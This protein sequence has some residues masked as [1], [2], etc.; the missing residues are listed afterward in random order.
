MLSSLPARGTGEKAEPARLTSGLLGWKSALYGCAPWYIGSGIFRAVQDTHGWDP[1]ALKSQDHRTVETGSDPLRSSSPILLLK[2]GSTRK[3]AQNH[4]SKDGNT[5]II[6]ATGASVEQPSWR[7]SVSLH[8][9][10]VFWV[11]ICTHC[12]LSSCWALLRRVCF[13]LLHYYSDTE[14]LVCI[15]EIFWASLGEES[16]CS[17]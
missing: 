3:V 16:W 5:I 13:C 6:W 4:A 17:Q 12:F 14:V 8:I 15:D 11:S 7:K 9:N 2:A 1:E 10:R